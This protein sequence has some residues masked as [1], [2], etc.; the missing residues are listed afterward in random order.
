MI[1]KEVPFVPRIV[2]LP[3]KLLVKSSADGKWVLISPDNSLEWK[4][5]AERSLVLESMRLPSFSVYAYVVQEKR[6]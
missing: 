4:A 1:P 2:D 6:S 3:R 5:I